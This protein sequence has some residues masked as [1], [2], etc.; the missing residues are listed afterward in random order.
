MKQ[1]FIIAGCNGAG[2]TTASYAMLPQMLNC[3]E[4]V[5]A[6]E[7]ARGLSPFN[8]PSMAVTAGRLMLQRIEELLA[9]DATFAIET[10]LAT[11]TYCRLAKRAQARGYKVS[12]LFFWLA[13]PDQAVARVAQRVKE[14]G[15]NVPINT[16]VRRYHA[17]ITNLFNIY[18]PVVDYWIAVDNGS[19]PRTKIAVGGREMPTKVFDE[20]K[21]TQ[22]Q[23]HV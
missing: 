10:T 19:S 17:G 3:M 18:M 2:K 13:S 23:A 21:Y 20:A 6:D 12:L 11:K 16:I 15:H 22:L 4:F 1:L 8:A 7:I 5:N 9:A 14:G